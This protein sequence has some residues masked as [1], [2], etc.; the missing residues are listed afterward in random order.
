MLYDV[1]AQKLE[2]NDIRYDMNRYISEVRK[3]GETTRSCLESFY[4]VIL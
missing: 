3:R 4:N 2:L 1:M